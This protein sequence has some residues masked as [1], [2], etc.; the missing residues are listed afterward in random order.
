[1]N[2]LGDAI[3]RKLE[4]QQREAHANS[5]KTLNQDKIRKEA[6]ARIRS[7]L[8]SLATYLAPKLPTTLVTLGRSGLFGLA[9]QT[10]PG[11]VWF[12]EPISYGGRHTIVLL[13]TGD[14]WVKIGGGGQSISTHLVDL[15]EELKI[16][17]TLLGHFFRID[18]TGSLEIQQTY[19]KEDMPTPVVSME[20]A[21]STMAVGFLTRN[22]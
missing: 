19:G 9:K 4:Q 14:I 17:L 10:S 8:Q 11:F 21:I 18:H 16:R 2:G 1:M 7:E 22:R 6:A 15:E 3:E 13:T 12:D 5:F 20:E